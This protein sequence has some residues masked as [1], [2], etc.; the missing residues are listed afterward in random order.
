MS[1]EM[2]IEEDFGFDRDYVRCT[3]TRR[4]SIKSDQI[5]TPEIL[6]SALENA[7]LSFPASIHAKDVEYLTEEE[8][9][10]A[11]S[12]SDLLNKIL[13]VASGLLRAAPTMISSMPEAG[14]FEM[15]K[16]FPPQPS[17][18]WWTNGILTTI[19]SPNIDEWP[20]SFSPLFLSINRDSED[21]TIS[22][23]F[24][25]GAVE[26]KEFENGTIINQCEIDI[27]EVGGRMTLQSREYRAPKAPAV[28]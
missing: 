18:A 27:F 9:C 1:F 19:P 21:I 8:N 7:Q 3:A 12:N 20:D 28:H 16:V 10:K 6:S 11:E 26:G 24:E 14:I 23:V 17:Y 4:V 22:F 2:Q 13:S 5:V 15:L 25:V